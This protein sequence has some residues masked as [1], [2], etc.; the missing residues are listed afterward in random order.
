[1]G[2]VTQRAFLFLIAKLIK[3]FIKLKLKRDRVNINLE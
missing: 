2:C 3:L 1:V